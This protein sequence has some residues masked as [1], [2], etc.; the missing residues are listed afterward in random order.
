MADSNTALVALGL[1]V[2]QFENATNRGTASVNSFLGAMAKADGELR[3]IPVLGDIWALTIGRIAEGLAQT[4]E[5]SR[6]FARIIGTDVKG[7]LEGTRSQINEI[8]VALKAI[9]EGSFSRSTTDF[10]TNLY[11]KRDFQHGIS[12]QN[13]RAEQDAALVERRIALEE[14][15]VELYK[16]EA[17]ARSDA[18]SKSQNASEIA[19]IEV[20]YADRLVAAQKEAVELGGPNFKNS[21]D[22][23]DNMERELELAKDIKEAQLQAAE[24]RRRSLVIDL[25]YAQEVSRLQVAGNEREIAAAAVKR[26]NQQV[27]NVFY[28]T[29]EE[30]AQA[31]A[32][33]VIAKNAETAAKIQYEYAVRNAQIQTEVLELEVTGQTRAANQ[34]KIRAQYETQIAEAAKSHNTELE[35][36]LRAQ[37]QS[38][39]LAEKIREY[40]LGARG[41]AA[42]RQQERHSL[43]IARI[44]ESRDRNTAFNEAQNIAFHGRP[45]FKPKQAEVK[46]T[47]AE[48]FQANVEKYLGEMARELTG[49]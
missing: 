30:K 26:A 36:S 11:H 21:K 7:S 48:Q 34:A 25:D 38:A 31:A 23:V 47:G 2:S 41:R 43:Q 28:G 24:I 4:R 37:Q 20:E 13:T 3:K 18:Y 45:S 39:Q 40:N 22:I 16:Q 46:L 8:N 29:A 10:L 33:L 17:T 14:T 6:E 9:R 32:Q 27:N 42:E 12:P 19:R 5:Q 1:D 35:K 44:I 49:H 15:I